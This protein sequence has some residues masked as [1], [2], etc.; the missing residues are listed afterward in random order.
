LD[1]HA[2]L[3]GLQKLAPAEM[4][5]VVQ[6]ALSSAQLAEI[7]QKADDAI[8]AVVLDAILSK[9]L[10]TLTLAAQNRHI[11][12]CAREYPIVDT[13]GRILLF[14]RGPGE[15]YP[16]CWHISGTTRNE[17]K[18]WQKQSI[19]PFGS[20]LLKYGLTDMELSDPTAISFIKV[21]HGPHRR[22]CEFGE[23]WTDLNIVRSRGG[24]IPENAQWFSPQELPP[25]TLPY[26]E[27]LLIPKVA[28]ALERM[29]S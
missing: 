1:K 28:A 6:K 15:R 10:G 22:Q 26:H 3:E 12:S 19:T 14:M 5:E 7:V 8:Q 27:E 29:R 23:V 16:E 25:R 17:E 18:L 13:E 21:P 24:R 11:T 4:L 2:L 9:D 20:V